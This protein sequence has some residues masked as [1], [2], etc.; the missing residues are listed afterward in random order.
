[1]KKIK[2][3][4][5]FLLAVLLFV[6]CATEKPEGEK[7]PKGLP[8]FKG[9]I[10]RTFEDSK[11]DYPQPLHAP[12]DA[13]NVILILLDDVGF[14]QAETFGGPISTPA[15]TKLAKEGV[16]YT[17]F[18]T[19]GICSP[20]RAALLTGRNHHQMG[21][22]TISELSTGYPGYHSIWG[23]DAASVA[24]V[25]K[26]NGYSTGAWGKWHNT[27]D[28]ETSPIGP[29]DR[30]PT[31]MGFEYFYGFQGGET[32]QWEPQLFKN[33]IPV[34]PGKTPEQG[35][36]LTEDITED[37]ISW[38]RNQK[39]LDDEK[40]YFLYFAP[41]AAH[42]PLHAPK[43]WIAKFKGQFDD[44]WDKMRE[45]TL[46]RQKKMGIIPA[47]TKLTPRPESI[48]AWEDQTE[49][50]KKVYANQMEV[51]A[52]FLAHTDYYI[53]KLI[54][55]ARSLPGGENTIV[56]YVVGDNGASAE[57]SM[58]GTLNNMMTQN[59]F[60][61]SIER[62]LELMDE[63][64]G[65]NHENHFAVPWAWAGTAP[66]QWMKRVPSHFGGT[67][68]GLV[69]SWP[70]GIK[71]SS[72]IRTQFH[73]VVDIVPTIYEI[74]NI[75]VPQEVNGVQ[76]LDMAG[77][78]M[79]YSFDNKDAESTR[80]TQY[81]ET[82]G[83]RAIY[84]E[85]WVAASF[86]GV[87]WELQGS[88]GFD[89]DVWEL[90]NIEEDFSQANNLADQY[91]EKLEELKRLF[92]EEAQKYSV[93]PLDDR[94]V[95]RASNP[96]RPSLTK[97]K[98]SFTYMQGTV[99][100]PEGSAPKIYARTHSITAELDYK[101]GDEGVIVATGGSAAGYTFYI[102]DNRLHYSYNFFHM[103]HY[104]ISS[105]IT[106]PEGKLEVKMVYTQE[107]EEWGGGGTAQIFVNGQEVGK[108]KVD[109]V[110]PARFSATETMD[111][112][113]DLGAPVTP[114]YHG[115]FK[116]PNTIKHVTFDLI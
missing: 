84:N 80:K 116:Y 33:T 39:S 35:Y 106:L 57:G 76:Q 1:M 111:I 19:T 85:G 15:L 24:E 98:N 63:V 115:P 108:G 46:E 81:F 61:D 64:G 50:A 14:G 89:N 55:E 12:E 72:E 75:K 112:G 82:G 26:Q 92:D 25:L 27:P 56:M 101:P 23:K 51:F 43:E 9:E 73:H 29:F 40:P 22:G 8:E 71:A 95:E 10:G 66:F 53:G 68:N 4:T 2:T 21:F 78:S 70:E 94:F 114:N 36:H 87:P 54:E 113:M 17:Q 86:H 37:A 58:T 83:H 20:T 104:D 99:R 41:G 97:G 107:S 5:G 60:P 30:W 13:P 47:D 65:K 96:E 52:A 110:V 18:H 88:I 31:G 11:E 109:K 79:A 67:R 102:K 62:Q 34:E 49:D 90:Y 28:W 16:S 91:P 32:S 38:L 6:G 42:A 44:G 93:Y 59:G 77:V 69:V 103:N 45:Y 48:P 7:L 3:L 74:A 105:N 100:V